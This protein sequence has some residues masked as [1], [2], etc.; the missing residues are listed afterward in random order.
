MIYIEMNTEAFLYHL[1]YATKNNPNNATCLKE[2][3][4]KE[5]DKYVQLLSNPKVGKVERTY[6]KK[7]RILFYF[8][9][10]N[11]EHI[12]SANII[13]LEKFEE[14][15]DYYFPKLFGNVSK[16]RYREIFENL[17]TL[18]ENEYKRFSKGYLIEV[19]KK[20]R[21]WNAYEY[22]KLL[23]VK[24]CP[25][26]NAQFTLTINPSHDKTEGGPSRAE[27]DHFVPKN[28]Y[29]IFSMSLYNFLV[30]SL[31]FS[32]LTLPSVNFTIGPSIVSQTVTAH[33]L[34]GFSS[35]N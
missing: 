4:I 22:V 23:K 10:K 17:K 32:F 26:C 18:F 8:L 21:Y 9:Y 34:V 24:V 13:E 16:N 6:L 11:I 19:N 15:F 25:Y 30:S 5:R 14:H 1:A 7:C 20:R 35:F 28:E 2:K 29:P 12:I 3:L 33:P 31:S 27:L